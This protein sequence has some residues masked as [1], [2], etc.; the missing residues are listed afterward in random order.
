L[1]LPA[2]TRERKSG[3]P[4]P[5]QRRNQRFC[6]AFPHDGTHRLTVPGGSKKPTPTASPG[7]VIDPP[8][9]CSRQCGL[10]VSLV[11]VG[12]RF[13]SQLLNL[14]LEGQLAALE[15]DDMEI[16]DGRMVHRAVDFALDITMLPLQ[17]VKMVGKRHDWCSLS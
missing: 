2:E 12:G 9:R 13:C 1:F 6:L 8:E 17:L 14:V 3:G 5:V 4:R 7:K 10:S 15:I 11:S 16:V